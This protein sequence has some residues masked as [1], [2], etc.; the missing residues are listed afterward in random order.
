MPRTGRG[1]KR[2]GDAQTAYSNRTDLNDRG[3]Q[4]ITVA[5]GQMYGEGKA[6]ADAQRAVPMSGTPAPPA[7]SPAG[8]PPAPPQQGGIPGSPPSAVPA[9]MTPGSVDLFAPADH[10]PPKPSDNE[11]PGPNGTHVGA[12]MA[13][14][15]DLLENAA[16]SPYA[17]RQVSELAALARTMA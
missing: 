10:P 11:I 17:T 13:N 2:Q 16:N 9:Q 15:A 7:A 3:P 1:G 4:P 14:V 12:S 6:Q 5:P 8:P